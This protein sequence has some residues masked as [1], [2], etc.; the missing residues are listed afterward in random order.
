[1]APGISTLDPLHGVLFTDVGSSQT[2]SGLQPLG[3]GKHL[4]EWGRA[5]LEACTC[6]FSAGGF[7]SPPLITHNW[8]CCSCPLEGRLAPPQFF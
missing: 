2:V 7:V 6:Y 8:L 1:M 5:C 4:V 3:Q